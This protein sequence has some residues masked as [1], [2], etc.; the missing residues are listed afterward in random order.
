MSRKK[1]V[2]F[3][4]FAINKEEIFKTLVICK[5]SMPSM[6]TYFE[7]SFVYFVIREEVENWI[8]G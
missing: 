6:H 3:V 7:N 8:E 4:C 1:R 5:I 2:I